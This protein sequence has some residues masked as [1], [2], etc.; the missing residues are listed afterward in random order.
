VEAPHDYPGQTCARSLEHG[1]V[2]DAGFVVAAAVVDDQDVAV[3]GCLERFEKDVDAA[4]VA[5][6]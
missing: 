2:T 5:R 4:A 6:R 1:E 3:L